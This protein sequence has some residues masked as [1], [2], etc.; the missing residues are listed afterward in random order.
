M[1]AA[2]PARRALPWLLT[3]LAVAAG[4][5]WL[6]F[7]GRYL[8]CEC[9]T[10][11]LFAGTGDPTGVSQH[12]A[13][14]YTPSHIIHGFLFFGALWL[15]ARR[16]PLSWRLLIATIVEVTWE[17]VENAPFIIERYRAVTVSVDY[18]GDTVLN[19]VCDVLA[20]IIGFGLARILPVW[21][22]AALVIGFEVLTAL[23]IRDGLAL[24]VLMLLWPVDAVRAWQSA[25]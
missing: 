11:K 15:V 25:L 22:S 20:M 13:D 2:T 4:A 18:N 23:I 16:L 21:T 3:V 7:S 5:V 8:I 9:G 24:N 14:W 10:V 6:W 1:N 17:L 19:S 12:V